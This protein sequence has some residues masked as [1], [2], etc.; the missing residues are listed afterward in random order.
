MAR[1]RWRSADEGGRRT[2][3]PKGSTFA[4]TAVFVHGGDQQVIPDWPG[5]GEHFSVLL[6]N[7]G[8]PVAGEVQ[9]KVDFIARTLV[10][11]HLRPG[12]RF[13]VM[14]GRQPVAEAVITEVFTDRLADGEER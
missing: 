6:D 13:V 10:A 7:V 12:A 8:D 2:W 11:E 9:A 1:I 5:G 14:E 4:A 3:P